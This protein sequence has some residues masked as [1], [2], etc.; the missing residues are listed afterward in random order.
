M[1]DH[2]LKEL[3]GNVMILTLN[4][5]KQ[6]NAWTGPMSTAL[7]DTMLECE[8]DPRVGCIVVTGAGRGF[9]AGADMNG[10]SSM[11]TGSA[12]KAQPGA[13]RPKPEKRTVIFTTTIK[14]PVIAAINGPVAG[15]GLSFA[16]ACDIR[17]SNAKAKFTLAF[18]K[19]GLVAEHGASWTLPKLVGTGNALYFAMS[20]D[21]IT[22]EEAWRMGIVQKVVE[23]NVL[24]HAVEFAQRLADT[25]SPTSMATM[26]AQMW[27]HPQ[28]TLEEA[29]R[30]SNALMNSSTNPG[31]EDFTEGVQSFMQKRNPNF[32]PLNKRNPVMEMGKNFFS[33]L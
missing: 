10:L 9:C 12:A 22:G 18:S 29:T 2:L 4:R 7:Y 5:P 26:K 8:N 24:E 1:T 33:K 19:R 23:D 11:S 25:V 14:K 13:P 28:L 20:S 15:I 16:L 3:R 32:K 6:L 27:N 31:N 30:Q 21:V 17:F